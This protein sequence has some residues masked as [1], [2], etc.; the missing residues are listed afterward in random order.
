MSAWDDIIAELKPDMQALVKKWLPIITKL[1]REEMD[2]LAA[3]LID[4]RQTMKA[5]EIL[6]G[7]MSAVE[8]IEA[9]KETN[10]RQKAA[11]E[12][13]L[14]EKS[15]VAAL[16]AEVWQVIATLVFAKFGALAG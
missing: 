16:L 3:Y 9:R 2:R 13:A 1:S 7:K 6:I 10:A 14:T 4:A 12:R 8:L 5:Y 11:K 15:M